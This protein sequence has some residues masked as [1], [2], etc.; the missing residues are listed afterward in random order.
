M[1]DR[2]QSLL[3]ALG[4]IDDYQFVHPKDLQDGK[5][6]VSE[7]DILANVPYVPGC[8]I[9]FDHHSSENERIG[10]VEFKGA[11]RLSPSCARVIWEYYGGHAKFSPDMDVMMT[12]VDKVDSGQLTKEEVLNPTG[13]ILLGFVMDPRTGLGRYKD[14]RISNYQLMLDMIKYCGAKSADEILGQP[15]V[16][17]R[18][19]RYFKQQ[20]DFS[21]MLKRRGA[22]NWTYARKRRF[23]PATASPL[24]PFSRNAT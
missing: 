10:N 7:N 21:A 22:W 9:W 4:M 6:E 17:E 18:T 13:W 20:E 16:K 11:A 1:L 19:E 8:G 3:N 24:M 2:L 12:A 23:L 14:Y 15:D 5:V